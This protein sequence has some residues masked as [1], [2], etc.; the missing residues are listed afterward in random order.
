MASGSINDMT[1]ISINNVRRGVGVPYANSP[2]FARRI[3]S[4]A[5]NTTMVITQNNMPDKIDDM[6]MTLL[7]ILL[8]N[9]SDRSGWLKSYELVKCQSTMKALTKASAR[10]EKYHESSVMMKPM[11]NSDGSDSG[12]A[13]ARNVVSVS[14]MIYDVMLT[15]FVLSTDVIFSV[16]T[17]TFVSSGNESVTYWLIVSSRTLSLT[18]SPIVLLLSDDKD[19]QNA[20][21]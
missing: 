11:G 9:G 21:K 6:T 18:N 7:T 2:T 4:Y 14:M 8:R 20:R 10:H 17:A 12:M 13:T 1:A 16:L 15:Y 5:R 19:Y 3:S